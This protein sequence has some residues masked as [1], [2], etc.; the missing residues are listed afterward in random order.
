MHE[1]FSTKPWIKP[2][3][4]AGSDIN[5]TDNENIENVDPRKSVSRKRKINSILEDYLERSLE[6]KKEKE[7]NAQKRHAEKMAR[8]DKMEAVMT[9]MF[10]K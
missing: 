6:I 5:I 8:L 1:I 9:E 4:V 3:A 2:V 7:N 10:K